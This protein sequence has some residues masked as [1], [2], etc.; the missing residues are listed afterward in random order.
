MC[1]LHALGVDC[2]S[3]SLSPHPQQLPTCSDMLWRK[4]TREAS[5]ATTQPKACLLIFHN[6]RALS[7]EACVRGGAGGGGGGT[8]R[9]KRTEKSPRPE[10]RRTSTLP[11][12]L[13]DINI[14]IHT[15]IYAHARLQQRRQDPRRQAA[16]PSSPPALNPDMAVITTAVVSCVLGLS[17]HRRLLL[18][19]LIDRDKAEFPG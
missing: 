10:A 16:Q 12:R 9:K 7:F 19:C 6:A 17:S 2:S 13:R 14:Y 11:G 4:C 8:N 1:T 3:P 18:L 15:Y 5:N